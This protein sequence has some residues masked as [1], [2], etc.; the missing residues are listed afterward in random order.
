LVNKIRNAYSL[1]KEIDRN[2]VL[3]KIEIKI[4]EF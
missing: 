1:K 2:K 4:E 3:L